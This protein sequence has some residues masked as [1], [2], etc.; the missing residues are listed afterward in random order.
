MRLAALV[1]AVAQCVRAF[2]P[3]ASAPRG[4]SAAAGP[5]RR[6]AAAGPVV[7]LTREAGKNKNLSVKL[8][9]MGVA[10]REL[11]CVATATLPAASELRRGACAPGSSTKANPTQLAHTPARHTQQQ[12]STTARRSRGAA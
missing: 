2:A 11:P 5:T 10:T 8:D 9:G 4:A 1:L 7:Y 12:R 6:A 3:A